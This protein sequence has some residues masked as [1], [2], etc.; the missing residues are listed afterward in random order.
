[1][2]AHLR[3]VADKAVEAL[4]AMPFVPDVD[5]SKDGQPK[6]PYDNR[7][8]QERWWS[9]F[10]VMLGTRQGAV[11]DMFFKQLRA[12]VPDIWDDKLGQ[13]TV[14]TET[15]RA[16]F[17]LI[18]SMKPK[19]TAE[20]AGC[21]QLVALHFNNMKLAG[22]ISNWH[23]SDARTLATM[24]RVTKAYFDGLVSLRKLQG[25]VRKSKQTIRVENHHHH[26][27]HIH[28]ETGGG[29]DFGGR[30]HAAS[31]GDAG[32]FTELR[33][34][35]SQGTDGQALSIPSGQRQARLPDARRGKGK[36]G[37]QGSS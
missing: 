12:L 11:I 33:S 20:A 32:K 15:Q 10:A 13:W 29:S 36:R 8:D 7:P 37:P 1:M 27:Q 2:P 4:C 30:V 23:G 24:A 22:G 25:K 28:Y 21:A 35:P 5:R 16:M 14:D 19:T 9:M 18:Q 26:H 34:L 31:G 3:P 17:G 6:P